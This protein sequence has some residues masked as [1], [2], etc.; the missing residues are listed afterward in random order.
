M[1]HEEKTSPQAPA[2][3]VYLEWLNKSYMSRDLIIKIE[4][5]KIR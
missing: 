1:I 5:D 4:F 3:S 2:F